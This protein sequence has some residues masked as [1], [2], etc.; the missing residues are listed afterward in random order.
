MHTKQVHSVLEIV[1][2]LDTPVT[3]VNAI[4][5]Y[6]AFRKF[7]WLRSVPVKNAAGNFRGM[8]LSGRWRTVFEISDAAADFTALAGFALNVANSAYEIERIWKSNEPWGIKGSR[9]ATQASAIA[10]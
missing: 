8:V 5:G 6:E 2:K 4:A 3:A 7:D 10:M 9:L 1:D